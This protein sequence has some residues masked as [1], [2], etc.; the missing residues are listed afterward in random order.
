MT[1]A[2]NVPKDQYERNIISTEFNKNIFVEAGAGAGK[3]TELIN[4]II[5]QLL[6]TEITTDQIVVITFTKKAANELTERFIKSLR[7]TIEEEEQSQTRI[8]NKLQ[9]A[10]EN[11]IKFLSALSTLFVPSCLKNSPSIPVWA[12]VLLK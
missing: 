9:Q 8:N 5:N 10:Y 2:P 4:R 1:Q 12:S 7:E 3:T 6:N 11:R